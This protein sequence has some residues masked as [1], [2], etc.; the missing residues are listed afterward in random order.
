MGDVARGRIAPV[1]DTIDRF[2][3]QLRMIGAQ[4]DE[5]T[6]QLPAD[7]HLELRFRIEDELGH[8]FLQPGSRFQ[9]NGAW[10]EVRHD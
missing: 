5:I 3:L 6:V 8:A 9:Y 10:F 7:A 1:M 2:I 4:A